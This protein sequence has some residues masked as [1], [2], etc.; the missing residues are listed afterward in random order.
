MIELLV[1]VAIMGF[2]MRL[3]VTSYGNYQVEVQQSNG[4]EFAQE[5]ISLQAV[6]YSENQIYTNDLTDLGYSAPFK[7]SPPYYTAALE[8]CPG[9]ETLYHCAQVKLTPNPGEGYPNTLVIT[10]NT[11]SVWTETP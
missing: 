1:V 6:Y 7:S 9:P 3:T 10:A 4:R 5:I 2:V 11:R 8:A